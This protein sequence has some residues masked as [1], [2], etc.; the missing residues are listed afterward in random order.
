MATKTDRGFFAVPRARRGSARIIAL[1]L[2]SGALFIPS[3]ALAT[4]P[5]P[6]EPLYCQPNEGAT[7][8]IVNGNTGV[9]TTGTDC[10]S[11]TSHVSNNNIVTQPTHGTLTSDGAGNYLYTTTPA[12][13]TGLDTFQVHVDRSVSY[14]SGGPGDFSEGAGTVTVTFNVLPS[15]LP[16][17]TAA[18][19]NIAVPPG[20]VSPCPATFGCV[21]TA[22]VGSVSPSHGTLSFSGLVGTYTPRGGY[23]GAD[24]F[25]IQALGANN[26]GSTALDSGDISVQITVP[27]TSSPAP[28]PTL[29]TWGMVALAGILALAGWSAVRKHA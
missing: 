2:L 15:S 9:F 3:L 6:G 19:F 7:F 29:G 10:Y 13:Y 14:T 4:T 21:T 5:N 23:S 26:D 27:S 12:N 11:P 8:L 17:L 18:P 16:A 1:S 24:S 22:M 25:T 28:V 20:A